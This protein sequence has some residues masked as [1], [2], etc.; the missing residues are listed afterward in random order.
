MMEYRRAFFGCN[1]SRTI[2]FP[3]RKDDFIY[4]SLKEYD[5]L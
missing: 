1:L 2:I 5:L 4:F 3:Y